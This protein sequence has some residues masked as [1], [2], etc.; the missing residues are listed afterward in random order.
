M[1]TLLLSVCTSSRSHLYIYPKGSRLDDSIAAAQRIGM[2]FH[3]SRGSMSVGQKDGGLPPDSV[4]EKEAD[5]LKD[6]QRLIETYHDDGCYAMLRVVVAP[7][8][9]F[10]V[11]RDLMRESAALARQYRVSLDPH[12]AQDAHHRARRPGK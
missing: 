5:I 12:R 2:R 11:S 3:A 4:V 10:S 6:T 8:S 7:C 1:A 9:P